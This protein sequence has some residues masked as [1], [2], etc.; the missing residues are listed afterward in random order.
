MGGACPEANGMVV[1][2][3]ARMRFL[4]AEEFELRDD[5][6]DGLTESWSGAP[7]YPV[8]SRESGFCLS[9][10]VKLAFGMGR[11]GGPWDLDK[12]GPVLLRFEMLEP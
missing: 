9:W 4:R 2:S 10:G 5:L 7:E 3:R 8:L 6:A 1:L 12:L 11:V